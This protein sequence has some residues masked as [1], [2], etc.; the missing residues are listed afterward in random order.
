MVTVTSPC[1]IYSSHGEVTTTLTVPRACETLTSDGQPAVQYPSGWILSQTYSGHGSYYLAQPSQA[2]PVLE[3]EA[4][5]VKGKA[6]TG[7]A[8]AADGQPKATGEP[9]SEAGPTGNY[10]PGATA[11]QSIP[12]SSQ[13]TS[14]PQSSVH[15]EQIPGKVSNATE[16]LS[17]SWTTRHG[18]HKASAAASKTGSTDE[19]A[20]STVP[21]GSG[22]KGPT[23]IAVSGASRP[24]CVVWAI[25]GSILMFY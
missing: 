18:S 3:P 4:A 17:L 22:A 1:S 13:F 15:Y 5:S 7:G 21:L 8:E 20:Q 9:S 14:S 2:V 25:F 16:T 11:D 24:H 6:S 10:H 19:I 23:P 12:A